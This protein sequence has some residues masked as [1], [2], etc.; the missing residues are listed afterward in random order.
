MKA[1]IYKL[2]DNFKINKNI[3]SQLIYGCKDKLKS[4]FLS[5]CVPAYGRVDTLKECIDS[6]INQKAINC[7]YRIIISEDYSDKHN[8]IKKLITSYS[9]DR[10][11]YYVN[12]PALGMAANWNRCFELA[13]TPYV[14]L[15]HDDDYLYDNYVYTV[16]K[17]INS[18]LKFDLIC[19]DHD[20]LRYGKIE[21]ENNNKVTQIYKSL[22]EGK[23]KKIKS[24][25]FFY[26]GIDGKIVP[27]CGILFNRKKM[28][29]FGGYNSEYGY[30]ADHCLVQEFCDK[31][32]VYFYPKKLSVYRYNENNITNQDKT[33]CY[34]V[35]EKDDM[36][37]RMCNQYI[38]TKLL[39]WMLDGMFLESMAPYIKHLKVGQKNDVKWLPDFTVTAKARINQYLFTIIK[40]IYIYG[41]SIIN[42]IFGKKVNY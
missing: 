2:K 24:G 27:T 9:D 23:L 35:L 13:D 38:Y 30:S 14:A 3:K 42:I 22:Q 18:E 37:K 21:K 40:K 26:G 17:F 16:S 33:K 29:Q 25:N 19:F 31:N 1:E 11:I 6:I 7:N 32:K 5:I 12:K 20:L 36:R 15:L 39:K 41:S 8:E 4:P 28:L 34:F 10:I